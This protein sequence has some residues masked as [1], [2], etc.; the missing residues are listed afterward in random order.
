MDARQKES[1]PERLRSEAAY[2]SIKSQG[3]YRLIGTL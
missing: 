1:S 3:Q 2:R